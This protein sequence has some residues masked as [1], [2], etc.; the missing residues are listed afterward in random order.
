MA[1]MTSG[2]VTRE[3]L[4]GGSRR[5]YGSFD[6][7]IVDGKIYFATELSAALNPQFDFGVK[8]AQL[9]E[10]HAASPLRT[11]DLGALSTQSVELTVGLYQGGYGVKLQKSIELTALT[12]KLID[13]GTVRTKS[14]ELTAKTDTA[15][16]NLG[17]VRT[18]TLELTIDKDFP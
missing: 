13:L 5:P 18:K 9:F 12:T 10:L 2:Q 14:V 3:G 1:E 7:K 4:A 6:G 8:L 15:P 11:F 16:I 17:S